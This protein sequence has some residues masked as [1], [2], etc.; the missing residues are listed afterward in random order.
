MTEL[1]LGDNRLATL[2]PEIGQLTALR[3]LRLQSNQL[4]TLPLEIG[5]LR[6]L[7]ALYLHDNP[8]LGLPLEVLGPEWHDVFNKKAK[9]K[10]PAEI[11]EYYFR[12][13]KPE[14]GM[15]LKK[16]VS[17]FEATAGQQVRE[18][19]VIVIGDG[20][21]GKTSLIRALLHGKPAKT[22]QETTRDVIVEDWPDLKLTPTG[23]RTKQPVSVHLWDFGGQEPMHAAHPYFF[24]NRTLFLVVATAR[25]VGVEDRIS[26]WLKMVSTHGK[27]APALVA[28]NKVDQHPMDITRRDLCA[29]HKD[30]LPADPDKAFFPT[31]CKKGKMKG[32][33]ALKRAM[34]GKLQEM[35]QVWSYVPAEWMAAKK[36]I[37]DRREGHEDTLTFDQWKEICEKAQVADKEQSKAL[38]L[39]RQ[40]GTVVSFPEDDHLVGLGVLNPNWVTGAIYPLLTSKELAA[41]GGLLRRKDIG[42]LLNDGKRYPKHKHDWLIELMKKFELLFENE[43]RLLMPARLPKDTPR[44]ANDAAWRTPQTVQL[45]FH[46]KVLPESVISKFITRWHEQAW[47]PASWWR[48]GIAVTDRRKQYSALVRAYPGDPGRIELR[49]NGPKVA[50]QG[51]IS[52]LRGELERLTEP[53]DGELMFVLGGV[54]PEKY[55][56]LLLLAYNGKDRVIQRV[57]KGTVIEFDLIEELALIESRAQQQAALAQINIVQGDAKRNAFGHGSEVISKTSVRKAQA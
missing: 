44:W 27:G 19:R 3:T 26:Y 51:F 57:V 56:D 53:L 10:P 36:V 13:R 45:E 14:G 48:H 30:C 38:D 24:T 22:S 17:V 50:R 54:H 2:P 23:Q 40:L 47:Q 33:V 29:D 4:A 52:Q 41:A 1:H 5:E 16:A 42:T 18:A 34:I 32:I 20:A 7:E 49:V 6:A 28:V 37:E 11:L 31:S 21:S 15:D 39:L 9:P 25:D 8:G 35:D 55:D 43:G 12:I 46:C